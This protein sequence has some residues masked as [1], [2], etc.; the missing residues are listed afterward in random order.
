MRFLLK[1]ATLGKSAALVAFLC[2]VPALAQVGGN[3]VSKANT[4]NTLGYVQFVAPPTQNLLSSSTVCRNWPFP[5]FNQAA[6]NTGGFAVV[7]DAG[8]HPHY[9]IAC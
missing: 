6:G 5:S 9:V 8:G 4:A 3:G 2:A 7:Y 1:P